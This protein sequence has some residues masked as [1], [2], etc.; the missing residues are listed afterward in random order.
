M[1][2]AKTAKA[3]KMNRILRILITSAAILAGISASAQNPSFDVFSPISKYLSN[4]DVESLSAWLADNLEISIISSSNDASKNQAKQILK[5]FFNTY[6]PR[7]F[8]IIHTAGKGNMKY[9]LGSLL[10]GGESF[11]VTIF[12]NFDRDGYTIQQLEIERTQ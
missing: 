4:G 10:A 12:V 2:F 1:S 5:S 8:R 7:S 3:N 6:K 11:L 9:A